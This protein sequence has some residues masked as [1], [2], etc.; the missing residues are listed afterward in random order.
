MHIY[1]L[2][3]EKLLGFKLPNEVFGNYS[4][5]EDADSDNKLIN[6]KAENG[7]WFLY[8]TKNA[9]VMVNNFPK[10][11][12]EFEHNKFYYVMKDSV[13]YIIY[14]RDDTK[15]GNSYY[16]TH[17][18]HPY[19]SIIEMSVDRDKEKVFKVRATYPPPNKKEY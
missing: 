12:I 10:P 13:T 15:N 3:K 19:T 18:Y 2:T 11:E 6:I 8:S 5:D 14:V 9:S 4:F 17:K 1:L 16:K 7:K